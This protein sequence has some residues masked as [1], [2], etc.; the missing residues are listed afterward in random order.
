MAYGTYEDPMA[1]FEVAFGRKR[2]GGESE[3]VLM[4]LKL[5]EL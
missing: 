2:V 5:R 1:D 3:G 4:P